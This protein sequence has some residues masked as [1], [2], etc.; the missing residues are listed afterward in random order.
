MSTPNSNPVITDV[1]VAGARKGWNIATSSTLPNVV[2]AFIII[3]ALEITGALKG[4]GLIFSPIMGLFGLPGEA[5]AVLIGSWM[6]MGGGIG[7][8]IGLF[9]KGI[10]TGEHLAILA[11]AIYLMGS[12]VQYLG[13]ILGVIGTSGKRIPLM[14]G[15]SVLNAFLAMLLMRIIV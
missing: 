1:F 6:S 8:A 10:I 4:L 12:Q 11:P 15:I 5:A 3:K 7:V 9:D 13:R 2:M 14:I